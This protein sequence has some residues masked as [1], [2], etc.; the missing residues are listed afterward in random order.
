MLRNPAAPWMCALLPR[1]CYVPATR[2]ASE[3]SPLRGALGAG[4]LQQVVVVLQL[5]VGEHQGDGVSRLGQHRPGAVGVVVVFCRVVGRRDG[6]ALAPQGPA[7]AIIRC[8]WRRE[9]KRCRVV[10]GLVGGKLTNQN[11]PKRIKRLLRTRNCREEKQDYGEKN[12]KSEALKTH[13]FSL[14]VSGQV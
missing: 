6:A 8:G 9:G 13:S 10:R 12:D 11:K 7:A 1:T 2:S 5:E 4:D 3:D 14:T